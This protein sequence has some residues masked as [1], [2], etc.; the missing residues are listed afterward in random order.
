MEPVRTPAASYDMVSVPEA[1]KTVLEHTA[2]LHVEEVYF[3]DALGRTLA[4]D[5]LAGEPIPAYRASIKVC[6][7]KKPGAA[8]ETVD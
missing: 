1:V 5:V 8:N 3:A 2:P 6:C 7:A 4:G